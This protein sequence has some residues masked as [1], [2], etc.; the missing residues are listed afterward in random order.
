M[1]IKFNKKLLSMLVL[2]VITLSPTIKNHANAETKEYIKANDKVY[3]RMNNDESSEKIC[4]L[5]EGD[6]LETT[7]LLENGWYQVLFDG[8]IGYVCGDYVSSFTHDIEKENLIVRALDSVNVRSENNIESDKICTL[9]AGDVVEYVDRE[10]NGWYKVKIKDKYGYI[11]ENYAV[12]DSE[13]IHKEIVP[14]VIAKD[15]LNV[16]SEPSKNSRIVYILRQNEKLRYTRKLENGWYEVLLNGKKAYVSGD[17][18]NTSE[19]EMT[20]NNVYK[21]VS[22]DN[23]AFIYQDKE[24]TTPISSVPQYEIGYVY[25]TGENYY[26]VNTPYGEGYVKKN[27]FSSLGSVSVVVDVTS[28]TVA[29]FKDGGYYLTGACV[30]GKN[31]TPTSYGLYQIRSKTKDYD[32]TKYNVHV[33]YWMPFT[34]DGQGLHDASWRHEFGGKIYKR[35]GSHGCV[36]LPTELAREIYNNVEK[37]DK[38]LIKR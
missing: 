5:Y 35:K 15:R 18:V 24:F 1:N 2:G 34:S 14:V 10:L 21:I 16:R 30:T 20:T 29:L 22:A 13:G 9:S 26:L 25:N 12:V 19:S 3:V 4:M 28:Q 23:D 17:Y 27:E 11:N 36:N 7:G 8:N 37:G 38:V 32:M 31:A 6:V 33:D